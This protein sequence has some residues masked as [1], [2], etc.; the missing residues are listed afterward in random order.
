M[1]KF[2][3]IAAVLLL[4]VPQ[5]ALAAVNISTIAVA[6]QTVTVTTSSAH[7][8]T[9]NIG[10]C[11][12]APASVCAVTKTIPNGTSF[13]FDQP[14]NT[15]VSA[16]ASSCGSG[17]LAPKAVILPVAASQS[18]QT[19]SYVLWLTTLAPLPKA[20]ASSAWTATAGS[21]GAST[22][23]NNA[24]AAGTFIEVFRSV[25]FPSSQ[26]SAQMQTYVQNDWTST[27]AA[28]AANT[29]PAAFYGF[30]WNGSA[31]VQQ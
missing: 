20:G 29:Q 22:A 25:A 27:Q 6:A 15:T 17:D 31:W 26:T 7:G 21:A 19:V 16:C 1:K 24:L 4:L 9:G 12:T 3:L 2:I 23:Q 14:T 10:V 11:L 28:F 30:V 18:T 5:M 13:T 8:L